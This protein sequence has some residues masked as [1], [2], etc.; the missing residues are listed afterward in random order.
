MAI[1][2]TIFK[3]QLS[4]N[5]RLIIEL[6]EFASEVT[7]VEEAFIYVPKQGQVVEFINLLSSHTIAYNINAD[8]QV[9]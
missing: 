7:Q 1:V 9:Q 3:S 5:P 4:T 2:I 8:G 6:A